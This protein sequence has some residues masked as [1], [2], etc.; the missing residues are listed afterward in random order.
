MIKEVEKTDDKNFLGKN[1]LVMII[2]LIVVAL[3]LI[4]VPPFG[5]H[6]NFIIFPLGDEAVRCRKPV[7]FFLV[8]LLVLLILVCLANK[9]KKK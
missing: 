6:T 9:L 1:Y 5:S 4:I 3:F 2:L 8:G 7:L